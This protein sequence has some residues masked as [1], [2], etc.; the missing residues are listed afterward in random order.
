MAVRR[1][2]LARRAWIGTA[3]VPV[4]L[5]VA[6]HYELRTSSFNTGAILASGGAGAAGFNQMSIRYSP[7]LGTVTL[8]FGG[9]VI[10][11]F[12]ATM[13]TPKHLAFE[14]VGVLDNFVFQ[15]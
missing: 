8:S 4:L 12:P 3:A 11:S 13:P 9:S 1:D 6:P 14:G 7:A 2:E 15:Q 10:G 5:L